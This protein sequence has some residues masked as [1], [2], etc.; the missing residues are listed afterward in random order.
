MRPSRMLSFVLLPTVLAAV[1][2]SS[3]TTPTTTPS[4][5]APLTTASVSGSGSAGVGETS[6][7]STTSSAA[8]SSAVSSAA[9]APAKTTLDAC[10]VVTRAEASALAGHQLSAGKAEDTNGGKRCT[11]GAGTTNV[12]WVQVAQAKSASAAQAEWSQELA[13]AESEI[14]KDLPGNLK[15]N[16]KY[17]SLSGVGDRAE[18]GSWSATFG[19]QTLR[20]SA[21]YLLKGPTF[22]AFGDAALGS[23]PSVDALKGQAQ[24]SAARLP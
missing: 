1:A 14:S 22:L 17:Q 24:T 13:K 3:S 15:A 18:A 6:A 23:V 9:A 19:G 2:C 11:Y 16:L 4:P 5:G 12:F 7:P 21:I 8:A 10:K 20:L